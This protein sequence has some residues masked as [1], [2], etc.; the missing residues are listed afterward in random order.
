[1]A[2]VVVVLFHMGV[3]GFRGGF[4]GVDVFF[5][6][7]GFLITRLLVKELSSTGRISLPSFW[8]RRA[9]RIL[10]AS[11]V[12]LVVTVVTARSMMSPLD[13]RA[14]AGDTVAAGAFVVNFVFAH[15]LGDY[16]GAQLGATSP[17]PLLHY[18]SLAVEEQ[19][20]LV[21]P[22]TMAA[23]TRWSRQYRRLLLTVV[24][25]IALVSFVV[26]WWLT[27]SHP[28]WAFYLLPARMGELLA[29]A[30]LAFAGRSFRLVPERWR[31]AAGWWGIVAIAA[32]VVLYDQSTPFPGTAS[33]LPVA[34]TCLVIGAWP[35]KY[36]SGP[37][38]VLDH[39]V[40][41]WLGRHSYA[42]YLWHWPALVLAEAEWGPLSMSQRIVAVAA[43]VGLSALSVR[44][45]ENPVRHSSWLSATAR[46]SLAMG[47]ALC[48]GALVVGW[49]AGTST[50]D[51]ATDE[52]AAAPVLLPEAPPAADG[53][54]PAVS[55]APLSAAAT[56]ELG[57][58]DAAALVS[59]L[60]VILAQGL[61]TEAV[62]S[63]LRPSLAQAGADRS[64]LYADNCV[65]GGQDQRLNDCHYGAE[66][67]GTTVVLY[68]DSHAA[69][70]F[71][72]LQA[73]AE[74]QGFEL[75]VLV[76]GGCP[77]PNVSISTPVLSRTCPAWR[78]HVVEYLSANRP[79][80]LIVST[81][82]GY[83]NPVGEWESGFDETLG[84]IDSFAG[85]TI[86]LGDNPE[87]V[88]NPPACL[89]EH[90]HDVGACVTSRD[91]AV[92]ADR[93]ARDERLAGAHRAHFI[94]PS[95]WL[96]TDTACPVI[97]GDILLYRDVTH[98][99]T[100]ATRWLQPLLAA[101]LAPYID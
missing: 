101:E 42:L 92:D 19:F 85:Q 7:S 58:G 47:A 79:D 26:S 21:W 59:S 37:T 90:V 80:V 20:Y 54:V 11:F 31:A 27:A 6:L 75:V 61:E 57:A 70:W 84:R 5:V 53:P 77:V 16:F 39:P 22:L 56:V 71:P 82:N 45:V 38:V 43:A 23:L 17:S 72:P 46:R 50:P 63:N 15:R 12:V 35:V 62:P 48:L 25:G 89:S 49:V 73:L 95:D 93:V 41:Q 33:L 66:G 1:M 28:T 40:L 30:A 29:G 14:L 44:Y 60:Q 83:N 10:P 9:R 34:G 69:Q 86:V 36:V 98:L 64:Q 68:G 65:N 78:D 81:W 13:Q 52:Q 74:Q 91:R 24:G 55:D 97:I 32:A 88:S 51:L 3:P 87:S 4:V 2:V 18:W 96:C 8:A 94:D 99:T 76:K 67:S 100:V